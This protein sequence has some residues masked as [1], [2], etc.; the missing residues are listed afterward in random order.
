VGDQCTADVLHDLLHS[1][2]GTNQLPTDPPLSLREW[3]A[4]L[5]AEKPSRDSLCRQLDGW[6]TQVPPKSGW[7]RLEDSKPLE[8]AV[9]R[10]LSLAVSGAT[11]E[12]GWAFGRDTF[13]GLVTRGSS[14]SDLYR[15]G[16]HKRVG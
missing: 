2:L 7:R 8:V 15:H 12:G 14:Q 10:G 5:R 6:M 4:S 13:T 1:I 3:M 9:G 16:S 11:I